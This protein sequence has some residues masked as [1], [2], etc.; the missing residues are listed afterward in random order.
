M[1]KLFIL[2][3]LF[4]LSVLIVRE[5]RKYFTRDQKEEKL[6]DTLIK[7]DLVDIELE[8]T[9]EKRVSKMFVLQ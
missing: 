5:L 7:G 6:R 2:I 3:M 8:I 4:F 9:G 1:F